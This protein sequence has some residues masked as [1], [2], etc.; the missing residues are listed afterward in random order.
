[1]NR[2]EYDERRVVY[3]DAIKRYGRDLQLWVLVEEMSELTKEICKV[4]RGD[5]DVAAI[6]EEIADVTIMLEQAR[7]IFGANDLVGAYMDEKV[8]RLRE[9]LLKEGEGK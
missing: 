9:R 7:L 1:M 4:M 5:G 3:V 2:I 6:A 8:M